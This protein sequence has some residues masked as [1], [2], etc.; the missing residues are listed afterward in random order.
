MERRSI[1]IN[2]IHHVGVVVSSIESALD[3]YVNTLGFTRS[4]IVTFERG[5]KFRSVMVNLN[6]VTL[7]LIEPM[8]TKGGIQSFLETRG[9]GIHHISL[10]VDDIK[11]ELVS[12]ASKGISFAVNEPVEVGQYLVSFVHPA[13]T[14]GVLMELVQPREC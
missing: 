6:D 5:E 2:K 8:D 7:E 9:E 11:D 3:I 12:L 13:S 10:E 14:R 1:M 4:E